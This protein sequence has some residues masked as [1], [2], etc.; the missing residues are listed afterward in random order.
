MH[1]ARLLALPASRLAVEAVEA[2]CLAL[3]EKTSF[4]TSGIIL[5]LNENTT[6]A[7]ESRIEFEAFVA[8]SDALLPT[9]L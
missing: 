5:N 8:A 2:C 7:R 3:T 1:A 4:Y 6:F 9:V